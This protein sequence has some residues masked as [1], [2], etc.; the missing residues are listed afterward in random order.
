MRIIDSFDGN[1][2]ISSLVPGDHLRIIGGKYKNK[3]PH[4]IFCRWPANARSEK[5]SLHVEFPD[6]VKTC[7]RVS[8]VIK[9]PTDDFSL[10]NETDLLNP[11]T[12]ITFNTSPMSSNEEST[13]YL[14]NVLDNDLRSSSDGS[15]KNDHDSV[16]KMLE[17]SLFR[18]HRIE[19]EITELRRCA[20]LYRCVGCSNCKETTI[21]IEDH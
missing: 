11:P 4:A 17:E 19:Q 13:G 21:I 1:S 14:S 12:N 5:K 7:L 16:I 15:M 3:Y 8:S 10:P 2:V 18:L 6:G 20:C 9:S